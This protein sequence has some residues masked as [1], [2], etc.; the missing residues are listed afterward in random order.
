MALVATRPAGRTPFQ[1]PPGN[2]ARAYAWPGDGLPCL[3]DKAQV[4]AET[5]S[6]GAAWADPGADADAAEGPAR[7]RPAARRG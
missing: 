4:T 3:Q 5:M 2:A 6:P 1:H 7:K